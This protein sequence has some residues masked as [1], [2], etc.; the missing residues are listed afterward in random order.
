MPPVPSSNNQLKDAEKAFPLAAIV[1]VAIIGGFV[2][3]FIIYKLYKYIYARRQHLRASYK[4][5]PSPQS[6]NPLVQPVSSPYMT[7][8]AYTNYH[9]SLYARMPSYYSGST[10]AGIDSGK[11][12]LNL[13]LPSNSSRTLAGISRGHND[14]HA[15]SFNA[16]MR[17][18]SISSV[19]DQGGLVPKREG[20]A[21]GSS[22]ESWP[23]SPNTAGFADGTSRSITPVSG[24]TSP[25]TAYSVGSHTR[26][27]V[28]GDSSMST[29]RLRAQGSRS[30]L[31]FANNQQ[32]YPGRDRRSL[33]HAHSSSSISVASQHSSGASPGYLAPMPRQP[34]LSGPPHA[35]HSRVEIVP[36]RPLAPPPGTVVATDKTTLAF[37]PLSGIGSGNALFASNMHLASLAAEPTQGESSGGRQHRRQATQHT[38]QTSS[39]N[40]SGD[41]VSSTWFNT[42]PGTSEENAAVMTKREG[43]SNG[44]RGTLSTTSEEAEES[45]NPESSE[46][47][48]NM[49][50]LASPVRGSSLAA[51]Q[52]QSPL[53]KL[54][55]DLQ[56]VASRTSQ[57]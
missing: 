36:P 48:D 1:C 40:A 14:S 2:A 38:V 46:A 4:E 49:I 29:D 9:P 42:P 47:Q 45:R 30:S 8:V 19:M 21:S 24:I 10:F 15:S 18:D 33:V 12:D 17:T 41:D 57:T 55:V 22:G 3:I 50:R 6:A 43:S 31:L 25:A 26:P 44:S 35:R 51:A 39:S 5:P 27:G 11:S 53:D 23:P 56:Q 20:S 54:K 16:Q 52:A 37:S 28:R 34:R 13:A 7:Q 32:S